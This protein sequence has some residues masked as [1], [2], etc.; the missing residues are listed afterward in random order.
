MKEAPGILSCQLLNL[1]PTF[2]ISPDYSRV[3]WDKRKIN[4]FLDSEK[5]HRS[6]MRKLNGLKQKFLDLFIIEFF[7]FGGNSGSPIF[8]QPSSESDFAKNHK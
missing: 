2:N 5:L 7:S 8:F 1:E 6:R 4:Q 3:I